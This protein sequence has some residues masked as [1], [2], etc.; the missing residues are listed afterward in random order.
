[1]AVGL[2]IMIGGYGFD[3]YSGSMV[4][5][6]MFGSVA[7]VGLDDG[8]VKSI[9]SD[10]RDLATSSLYKGFNAVQGGGDEGNE[11]NPVVFQESNP[12]NGEAPSTVPAHVIGQAVP[13]L[14]ATVFQKLFNSQVITLPQSPSQSG[15]EQG[16]DSG[17]GT[18]Q[19]PGDQGGDQ[20]PAEGAQNQQGET[21]GQLFAPIQSAET[22]AQFWA[23]AGFA[24]RSDGSV[25]ATSDAIDSS[26]AIEVPQQ[27]GTDAEIAVLGAA[28]L[29]VISAPAGANIPADGERLRGAGLLDR[30]AMA[31]ARKPK[32]LGRAALEAVTRKWFGAGAPSR[33][34]VETREALPAAEAA[35]STPS[36]GVRGGNR[37]RW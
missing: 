25:R 37:I 20:Q 13:L 30:D 12:E 21:Q 9:E 18:Q 35:S 27:S 8:V 15:G 32:S 1:M 3:T 36:T 24:G 31:G 23:T 26:I 19:G 34:S 10:S 6:L 7:A 4:E 29:L 22:V 33:A 14:S 11:S 17:Q 28:G 16:S 5:D 2:D